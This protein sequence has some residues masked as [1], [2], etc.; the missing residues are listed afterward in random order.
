M[1]IQ[2]LIWSFFCLMILF[3]FSLKGCSPHMIQY[4]T[5][6]ISTVRPLLENKYEIAGKEISEGMVE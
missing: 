6:K 4:P 3:V 2:I 1:K 5:E